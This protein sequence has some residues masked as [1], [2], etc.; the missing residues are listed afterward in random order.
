MLNAML[1]DHRQ[2]RSLSAALR[3]ML[4]ADRMPVGPRL[5]TTRW[6]LAREL[7][8]HI[9]VENTIIGSTPIDGFEQ[10]FRAHVAKW[11]GDRIDREW[12]NFGHE[13]RHILD[14]LERK[15]QREERDF[16]H[17]RMQAGGSSPAAAAIA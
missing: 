7:L 15:M 5:G 1:E 8:R 17:P 11:T 4:A 16:Y 9:A 3:S 13:L 12:A 14:A 6:Q 10:R 2:I